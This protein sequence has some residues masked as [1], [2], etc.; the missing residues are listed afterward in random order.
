MKRWQP[1]GIARS[2]REDRGSLSSVYWK[3]YMR[4]SK[5]RRVN[6]IG[7]LHAKRCTSKQALLGGGW[8]ERA[9]AQ[10]GKKQ[11]PG[12]DLCLNAGA[13]ETSGVRRWDAARR[14]TGTKADRRPG[15]KNWL[16]W[17]NAHFDFTSSLSP[18]SYSTKV[19]YFIL[20]EVEWAKSDWLRVVQCCKWG[21]EYGSPNILRRSF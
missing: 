11:H 15:V 5:A 14:L 19:I 3:L 20:C 10:G 2:R 12:S 16:L 7:R 18:A 17:H 9:G 8:R 13:S 4:S 6:E 21:L 1:P